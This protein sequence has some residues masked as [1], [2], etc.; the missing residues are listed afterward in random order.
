MEDKDMNFSSRYDLGRMMAVSLLFVAFSMPV[1]ASV[2]YRFVVEEEPESNFFK[3]LSGEIVLSDEAVSSGVAAKG[4]IESIVISGGPTMQE[5]N[6]ITLTYLHQQFR[7]LTVNLSADRKTISSVSATLN[8]SGDAIDNWVF[9]YQRPEHPTL[10]IHEFVI[11]VDDDSILLETTILPVPPTTHHD[12]FKGEWRRTTAC[13]ICCCDNR[14]VL[15]GICWLDWIVICGGII[16]IVFMT[17]C[18]RR[19]KDT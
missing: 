16:I 19:R 18:L 2:T 14:F 12:L 13:W 9:H 17:R 8:P 7:D 10:N 15:K 11:I 5:E 3:P 4:Q 1:S 6:R